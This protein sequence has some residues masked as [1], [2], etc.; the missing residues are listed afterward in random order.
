VLANY[1]ATAGAS[2][3][4]L[5]AVPEPATLALLITGAVGGALAC[6]RRV[7]R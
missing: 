4:R 6:L 5:A 7:G 2:G 1:G 3:A